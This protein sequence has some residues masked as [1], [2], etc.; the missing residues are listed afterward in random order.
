MIAGTPSQVA[1]EYQD[2]EWMELFTFPGG[3]YARMAVEMLSREDIPAYTQTLHAGGI[4]GPRDGTELV[5]VNVA[6]FV[7][8]PDLERALTVIEPMIDEIPREFNGGGDDPEDENHE[9]I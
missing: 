3:L 5:G 6:V 1:D 4:Y 2:A 8:E 9:E 7:L